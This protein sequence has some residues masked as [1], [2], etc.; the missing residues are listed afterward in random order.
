M[1]PARGSGSVADALLV[2][3]V[4][5]F[6]SPLAFTGCF[7]A[8]S[9]DQ[10]SSHSTT[11]TPTAP[12][13]ATGPTGRS[14]GASTASPPESSATPG[15][16][17]ASRWDAPG[18]A[19]LAQTLAVARRYTAALHAET[20]PKA[21]LFTDAATWDYWSTGGIHVTGAARIDK[22]YQGAHVALDWS[23]R[24]HIMAAPGVAVFEG[25]TTN[26]ST[27]E[28]P[29]PSAPWLGLLAVDGAKIVHAEIFQQTAYVP[30][31]HAP[32]RACSAAPGP[33]DTAEAAKRTGAAAAD[34]L[35]T[36]DTVALRRLVAPGIL[37]YD[38]GQA[39]GVRGWKT[40]FAW[41]AKV[42]AVELTNEA[43]VAGPGWAV[44][45]WTL[46]FAL[47]GG[48]GDTAGATVIEV[49]DGKVVRMTLY[50]DG[51]TTKL[52]S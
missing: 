40:L 52:Q 41:W 23:K 17:P 44:V 27:Y 6:A 42:P 24:C 38:T 18:S 46:H 31:I 14:T 37:F 10:G 34:A 47:A 8:S 51:E 12:G 45:R 30:A 13:G 28:S 33:K 7:G 49:R 9:P 19:N 26:L 25:V 1:R 32:V 5:V 21:D 39:H 29:P 15:G 22:T 11:S 3:V 35:A 20:I 16:L 48:N 36:G 4:L 50:Y 2:G 43:P